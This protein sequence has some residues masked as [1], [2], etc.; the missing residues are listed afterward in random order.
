MSMKHLIKD[1]LEETVGAEVTVEGTPY[2]MQPCHSRKWRLGKEEYV[3]KT[4]GEGARGE[5]DEEAQGGGGGE[6]GR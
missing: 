5:G 3:N 1:M 2:R 6:E 4:R